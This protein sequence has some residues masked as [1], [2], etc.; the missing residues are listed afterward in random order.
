[1]M[2]IK[3]T[4][5]CILAFALAASATSSNDDQI[6]RL[7]G[8]GSPPSA[9]YSGFLQLPSSQKK[10]HYYFVESERS[11]HTD[12]V[13]LWLNGGPGCSSLDGLFYEQGPLLVTADGKSLI[14]NPSSWAGI[15]NMLY[16]EVSNPKQALILPELKKQNHLRKPLPLP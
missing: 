1:M 12:P 3:V 14:R 9:H 10:L 16:L 5:I 13:V 11:P 4:C 15:A 7:P 6:D 8:Y 2:M